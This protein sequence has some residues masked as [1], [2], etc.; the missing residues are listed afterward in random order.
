MICDFSQNSQ[1]NSDCGVV[2]EINPLQV[3]TTELCDN[4]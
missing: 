4:F 1:E 3:L 2:L